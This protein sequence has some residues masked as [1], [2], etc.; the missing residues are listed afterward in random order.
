[1]K[2]VSFDCGIKNLAVCSIQ[3]E[4]INEKE[5]LNKLS[6]IRKKINKLQKYLPEDIYIELNDLCQSIFIYTISKRFK[7][8]FWKNI[9][10]FPIPTE[11]K[12]LKCN[13]CKRSA[14][15]YRTTKL[16][17]CKMHQPTNI[18]CKQIKERD[19]KKISELEIITTLTKTLDQY[20]E[21]LQVDYILIEQQPTKN[22]KMKAIET[23]LSTYFGIRGIVDSDAKIQSI[24]KVSSKHKLRGSTKLEKEKINQLFSNSTKKK[25]Y[26]QRKDVSVQRARTLLNTK[27]NKFLDDNKGK[28]DDLCDAFLQAY[29]YFDILNNN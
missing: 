3:I 13:G 9:N 5:I 1:M 22:S 18:R 23:I 29:T 7:I 28:R 12:E 25:G 26:A 14:T 10:L 19:V 11:L 4:K 15:V 24:K 27:W 17:Y 8:L 6:E 16:G 21:L 2:I 20:P